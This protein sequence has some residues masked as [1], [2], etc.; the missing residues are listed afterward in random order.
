MI[1]Y[2]DVVEYLRKN[3]EKVFG[4][5]FIHYATECPIACVLKEKHGTDEVWYDGRIAGVGDVYIQVEL[6]LKE[7]ARKFD[8][9]TGFT[10]WIGNKSERRSMTGRDI[11]E[12]WGEI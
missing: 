6:E 8:D 10:G 12:L 7:K 1:K 2:S 5:D 11:L 9:T 3:P 4:K